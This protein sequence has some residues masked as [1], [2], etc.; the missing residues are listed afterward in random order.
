MNIQD[1]AGFPPTPSIFEM[2]AAN[3][4]PN[5]PDTVAAEKKSA[6]RVPSCERLYQLLLEISV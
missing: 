4:P 1:H 3:K 6:I 5:A 2:A